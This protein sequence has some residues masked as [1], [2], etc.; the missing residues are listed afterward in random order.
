MDLF[1]AADML[2]IERLK[3]LCEQNIVSSI[4]SENST[5]IFLQADLHHATCLRDQALNYILSRFDEISKTGGFEQLARNNVELVI[6]LL[7]KR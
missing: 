1:V 3:Q 5:N 2:G 4:T 7:K 6:E